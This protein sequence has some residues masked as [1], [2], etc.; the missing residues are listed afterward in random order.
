MQIET[1]TILPP[2]RIDCVSPEVM[3]TWAPILRD[4]NPIH[5]DRDA[6]KAKGLG[7]K[8]INQGPINLAYVIDMLQAAFPTG[9]ILTMANRF[10]D[11]VY[12]GDAVVASGSITGVT[13]A[14]DMLHVACDFFLKA[15]ARDLVIT[16]QAVVAVPAG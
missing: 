11:N 15:D 3:K 14:G 5:L 6:V 7:D 4:P 2:R 8:V 12:E 1:G 9:T 16:G 10:V 13:S